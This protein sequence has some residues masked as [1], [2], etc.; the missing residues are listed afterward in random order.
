MPTTNANSSLHAGSTA[1]LEAARRLRPLLQK[2]AVAN[3]AWAS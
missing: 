2:E 3:E 1:L